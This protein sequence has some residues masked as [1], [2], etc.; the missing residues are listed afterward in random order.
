MNRPLLG[1]LV[2]LPLLGGCVLTCASLQG[3]GGTR[4]PPQDAVVVDGSTL[5]VAEATARLRSCGSR[6]RGPGGDGGRR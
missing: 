2:V 4:Y 6:E 5:V 3:L 1:L